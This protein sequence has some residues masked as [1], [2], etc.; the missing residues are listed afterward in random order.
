M[1]WCPLSL[2]SF[3][4]PFI[5]S[6]EKCIIFDHPGKPMDGG[7]FST[8]IK[9]KHRAPAGRGRGGDVAFQGFS[10]GRSSSESSSSES[11][12]SVVV[13][14]GLALAMEALT[15]SASSAAA[16]QGSRRSPAQRVRWEKERQ[17]SERCYRLRRKRSGRT[18]PRRRTA[19]PRS[20]S[21]RTPA[22]SASCR[23]AGFP[24]PG[25]P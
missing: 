12:S 17:G 14:V 8:A 21:A 24:A 16:C 20:G 1:E 9:E 2:V 3:A 22:G 25:G 11:S 23:S 7:I 5:R 19:L 13:S 18:L 6:N 10:G 15:R 4:I